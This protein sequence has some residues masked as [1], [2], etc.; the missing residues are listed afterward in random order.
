MSNFARSA[1]RDPDVV[2]LGAGIIGAAIAR[3]LTVAGVNVTVI[4]ARRACAGSSGRCDGNLL[5]Q[6][7][8][9]REGVAIMKRSLEGYRS[10]A[11]VLDTDLRF[12]ERGSLVFYTDE[13]Q[14]AAGRDRVGWLQSVGVRAEYLDEGELREREPALDGPVVAGIDCH[15]DASVYPPAVVFGLLADA[16]ARG[17]TLMSGVGARRVLTSKDNRVLGVDT[18]QGV[19]RARWVVNAMGLW[20]ADLAVDGGPPIP[21]RPRQGVLLVTERAHGLL[22]RAVSE[23]KYMTLREGASNDRYEAPVTTAEPTAA[24][25]VLLGSSRRFVGHDLEVDP[26]LVRA[27]AARAVRFMSVL[28]DVKVVRS[29]AGLRPWT[30]DNHP[31]IGGTSGASGYLLAT[32]HEGEGIGLAPVTAELIASI[33][34]GARI[35]NELTEA[36]RRFDPDRFRGKDVGEWSRSGGRVRAVDVTS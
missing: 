30:P 24:G 6:T 1:T 16:V 33:V 3:E 36:L 31:V 8:A 7:K 29:F 17:A 23:A 35:D 32:G 13:A 12:H 25:N 28:G 9:D 19:V 21:I 15:D 4:E 26:A 2:V 34:T 20:S 14:A 11:R 18:D 5:V 10:W 22:R 27:I